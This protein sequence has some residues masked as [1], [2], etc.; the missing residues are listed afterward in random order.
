MKE[1]KKNSKSFNNRISLLYIQSKLTVRSSYRRID[2]RPC[3]T[4]EQSAWKDS[5]SY[6]VEYISIK[7]AGL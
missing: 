2:I 4:Y 7:F 5:G 6:V 3:S 1:N